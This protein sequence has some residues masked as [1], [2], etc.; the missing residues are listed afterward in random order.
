MKEME[1]SAI[2]TSFLL[3][4]TSD[5]P[6]QENDQKIINNFINQQYRSGNVKLIEMSLDSIV[7]NAV[8]TLSTTNPYV[9]HVFF[10]TLFGLDSLTQN[11]VVNLWH[12]LA[13]GS[14]K[15]EEVS[16][17]LYIKVYIQYYTW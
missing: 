9:R 2:I 12:K 8:S 3:I 14:K 7:K 17:A 5:G 13:S 4:A 1:L 6:L 15:R 10:S 16:D 11:E